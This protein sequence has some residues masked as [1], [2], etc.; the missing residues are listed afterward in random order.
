MDLH[1]FYI[2]LDKRTDR[3]QEVETELKSVGIS[4]TRI[5]GVVIPGRPPLGCSKAHVVALK[6]FLESNL[7]LALICE[8]DFQVHERETFR[9]TMSKFLEDKI[10]FDVVMVA[11][12]LQKET[13]GPRD[14]LRKIT[15]AQTTSAYLVS[16]TF[17]PV[18]LQNFEDSVGLLETCYNKT[19]YKKHDY[20]LD[21]YWQKLQETSRWYMFFP[22]LSHQRESYSDIELK[23]V[24]YDG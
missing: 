10:P 24:K 7:E 5:P 12:F 9:S 1:A 14:Y 19:G 3:K 11:S 17:A 22:R 8:D 15:G 2:N 21:I 6:A 16:K 20:C 13:P 23:V 4:F 18:L